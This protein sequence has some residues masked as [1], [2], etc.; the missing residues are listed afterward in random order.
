MPWK[1]V[2]FPGRVVGA[3]ASNLVFKERGE[4]S[5]FKRLLGGGHTAGGP[6]LSRS[7]GRGL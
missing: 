3:I 5:V 2:M 7:E 1:S 6:V 4:Q